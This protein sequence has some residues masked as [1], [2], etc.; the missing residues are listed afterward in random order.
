LLRHGEKDAAGV[1]TS[2]GKQA[3]KALRLQL[4]NFKRV[5]SSDSDRAVLTAKLLTGKDPQVDQRAGYATASVEVSNE[6]NA[7]VKDHGISFLDAAR[8]YNNPEVLRGIDE[9]A[10]ALNALIDELL[11]ELAEDEKA[12]IVSHDLTIAP[13]MGFRGVSAES[14]D[15][16]HGYV[17]STGG[18]KPFNQ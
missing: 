10:H 2:R 1:L 8:Q 15:P 17:I 18:V 7:L 13:A 11:G 6:I 4:A 5:I 12:L 3:A 9:Q 14:I 16:L